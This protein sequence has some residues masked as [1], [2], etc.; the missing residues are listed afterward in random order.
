MSEIDQLV[1]PV[2]ELQRDEF[3][4]KL[5]GPFLLTPTSAGQA[6][7]WRFKTQTVTSAAVRMLREKGVSLSPE[8]RR[9]EVWVVQTTPHSVWQDRVSVG[10]ARNNDIVL[11]DNSV[12]KLHAHFSCNHGTW[13]VTDAGS[14]NGTIHNGEA[15][16]R[17][18]A[19]DLESGDPITFGG[20]ATIFLDS[21][22]LY[23]FVA[24]HIIYGPKPDRQG[25]E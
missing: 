7:T 4:A 5:P 1:L 13:R 12:S 18:Q 20:I 14:R 24:R 16:K 8:A 6:S 3:V 11:V 9:Y 10:R 23:D 25:G 21:G 22:G 19:T 2:Q 17:D 15:L